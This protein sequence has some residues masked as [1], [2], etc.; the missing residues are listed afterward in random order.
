MGGLTF[1][2]VVIAVAVLVLVVS[3]FIP[4]TCGGRSRTKA[5]RIQCVSTLKQVGLGYVLAREDW[6]SNAPPRLDLSARDA[7]L[8][9]YVSMSNEIVTPK[10]M[11][12]PSDKARKRVDSFDKLT[13]AN[14]RYFVGLDV[15]PSNPRALLSGDR[16]IT[17]GT[18]SNGFLR[19]LNTNTPAGWTKELH[20]G[21]GNIGLADGSVQQFTAQRLNQHLKLLTNWP[22]RLAIP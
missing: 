8:N 12:C 19:V 16:H 3:L 9:Y 10:I 11:T 5:Q 13:T 1:I 4:S 6:P 2:E 7:V 14:I 22:V 18:L 17:G 21:Q 20:E 15:D